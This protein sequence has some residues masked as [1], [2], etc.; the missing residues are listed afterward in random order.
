V[1][2]WEVSIYAPSGHL[3]CSAHLARMALIYAD[4]KMV[5]TGRL[6]NSGILASR[7]VSSRSHEVQGLTSEQILSVRCP[8]CGAATGE[9]CELNPGTPR[10]EAHRDR[11]AR[12]RESW[13]AKTRPDY[14]G[15]HDRGKISVMPRSPWHLWYACYH[16]SAQ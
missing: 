3:F 1:T 9:V 2:C 5:T 6:R 11:K 16:G 14:L 13:K 4:V 15:P 12:L 7:N 8:T 10:T